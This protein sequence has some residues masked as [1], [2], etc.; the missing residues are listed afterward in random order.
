V[1][2]W[3]YLALIGA[4]V[5]SAQACGDDDSSGNSADDVRGAAGESCTSRRD[6]EEG[7]SC[8]DNRCVK[9]GSVKND[10]DG[11]M[12]ME[13]VDTRGEA[14]ESC[15]R[16]A[17]CRTGN[18]CVDN[19]CVNEDALP[20]GMVPSTRGQRGESCQ[21]RNDCKDDLACINQICI[22][23]DFMFS[24]S[25]KQCFR[26][27]CDK[28]D[29]C[30][31]SFVAPISCPSLQTACDG[32]D[33]ASCN[34]FDAQC[35]CNQVCRT[36]LCTFANACKTD[37]DCG[38]PSLHC[39]SGMCAQCKASTDC[40]GMD[41]QCVAGVCTA[42]CMHNEQCP[43]FNECKDGEC[44]KSGCKTAR[45]CYF[46]TQNPLS[47]CKDGECITPCTNDASCGQQQICD[48][49]HCVFVGCESDEEC[50]ALLGLASVVGSDRA[51]CREPDH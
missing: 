2:K 41:Q 38:A 28:D 15:T 35:K 36:N 33:T 31:E 32:G 3:L 5:A 4:L 8:I 19:V 1:H 26:V 45:E 23:S 42:G 14:G 44:V 11:G 34:A 46:A 20:A 50:R 16:R 43:L 49:G 13:I 47:E 12:A 7:L 37:V 24:V 22:E 21:A 30:C 17:D 6:C 18:A 9:P 29:D 10:D 48:D 27:Q 25:T 39:F 51:V 40:T